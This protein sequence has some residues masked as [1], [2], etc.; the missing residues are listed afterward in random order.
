MAKAKNNPDSNSEFVTFGSSVDRRDN[1]ERIL[2]LTFALIDTK[3]GLLKSEIFE[4]IPGYQSGSNNTPDAIEQM[5]NRDKE[6]IRKL[7]VTLQAFVLPGDSNQETRY[8]I[9]R[10]A[11]EWPQKVSFSALQ[12]QLLDLAARCW[13]EATVSQ[14]VNAALMRLR[15]LGD[16]PSKQS[17]HELLPKFRAHDPAFAVLSEAITARQPVSFQYRKP[18][19]AKPQTRTLHP[20][21]LLSVEGE[22]LV[23]G[24]DPEA[25]VGA[26]DY[27]S[28]LLR[29]IVNKKIEISELESDRFPTPT[30][31]DLDSSDAN[32]SRFRSNNVAKL[33]VR[34]GTAAW[35]HFE[36]DLRGTTEEPSDEIEIGFLD[37]SLLAETIR[38]F[39]GQLEVL[40]P[41]SLRD[42]VLDGLRKVAA[43]HA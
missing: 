16:T 15:A 26:G 34:P 6:D 43:A 9:P 4:T 33:R 14:E 19:E 10:Q 27:R 36:M 30:Q 23:Q 18:G 28:F 21:K 2:G 7:G 41:S 42:L 12:M 1:S 40:A 39:A 22:W 11:F 13:A 31:A 8:R 38:S 20:W 37:E 29:R 32:L 5:F 25:A 17:V 24:W 3:N 35:S